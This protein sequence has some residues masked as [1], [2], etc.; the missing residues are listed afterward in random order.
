MAWPAIV[1]TSAT[2]LSYYGALASMD[3]NP[4]DFVYEGV[5]YEA[6]GAMK[7]AYAFALMVLV[8]AGP[9]WFTIMLLC[10]KSFNNYQVIFRWSAILSFVVATCLL[11]TMVGLHESK[12]QGF[13][14]RH[15]TLI[16]CALAGWISVSVLSRRLWVDT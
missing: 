16:H 10:C 14:R 5:Y 3:E 12:C 11:L 9:L 4:L 1:S 7:A 2:G 15:A 8:I 6:D 13:S